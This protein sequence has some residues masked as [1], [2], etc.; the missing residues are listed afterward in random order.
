MIRNQSNALLSKI[1]KRKRG[2]RKLF[3]HVLFTVD[4][5][6]LNENPSKKYCLHGV[7]TFVARL[8]QRIEPAYF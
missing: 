7:H 6:F 4:N 3:T 5:D 2:V 1:L 8:Q